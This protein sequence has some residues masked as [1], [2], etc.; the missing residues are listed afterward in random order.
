MYAIRPVTKT[1]YTE[2]RRICRKYMAEVTQQKSVPGKNK[3][4]FFAILMCDTGE[5]WLGETRDYRNILATY[6]YV[7]NSAECVRAAIAR[8]SK[9]ELYFLTRPDVFSAQLLEDELF[10]A[11]L[12]AFRKAHNL[13][14]PG[15]LYVIRH[16]LTMDYFIVSDRQG[17]ATSTLL[18]NFYGRLLNQSSSTRNIAL[19]EFITNQAN[20]IIKQ[21]G[22]SINHLDKFDSREDEWLKRQVYIDDSKFGQNLNWKSVE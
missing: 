11:D 3:G 16:D 22:F 7:T 12:L 1:R 9:L 2:A 18:S 5:V 17:L 13:T 4:G 20:D 8:G 15:N 6:R 21:V 19:N 14:G 10:A